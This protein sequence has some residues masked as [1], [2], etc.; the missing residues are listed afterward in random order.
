MG[1]KD[2]KNPILR[3]S[4]SQINSPELSLIQLSL[5]SGLDPSASV[6]GN[7]S[8]CSQAKAYLCENLGLDYSQARSEVTLKRRLD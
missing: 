8:F 2:F 5:M 6:L 4:I 3:T 1:R 7:A